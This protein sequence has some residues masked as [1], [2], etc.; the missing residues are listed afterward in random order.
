MII[1]STTYSDISIFHHEE[2]YSIFHK[3]NFTK[4]IGGKEWLRRYFK[5][6]QQDIKSIIGVQNIIKN[7]LDHIDEWPTE[8]SNG[9]VLVIEKFFDY[10]LDI[11]PANP[12]PV[13]GFI[14]KW[15]HSPDYSIIKYSVKHFIDFYRG[16]RKLIQL[17][18]GK[19]LPP[20]IQFHI[21]RFEVLLK[22]IPIKKLSEFV[23][24][25]NDS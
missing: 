4:T 17:F 22:N 21:D 11:I 16:I 13:N 15:L 9:T 24:I 3:F 6:P 10:N 7:L 18:E 20:Q 5:E 2:E 25:N 14:Y 12:N 23:L 19:K 1:D 8:I